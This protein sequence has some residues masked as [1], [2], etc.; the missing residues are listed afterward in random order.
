M[1]AAEVSL[2]A[3]LETALAGSASDKR[4]QVLRQIADLFVC[5]AEQL[6]DAQVELFDDVLAQLVDRIESRARADL[7]RRLAPM[8]NAPPRV[9]RSLA[10]D[11]DIAVAGRVLALSPRLSDEELALVAEGR[12]QKHLM[13]IAARPDISSPLTDVLARRG[14]EEVLRMV[15]GNLG[16]CI[17]D[18]GFRIAVERAARDI[19]LA[20]K[21]VGRS[22]L[23][24]HRLCALIA[25]AT[26]EVRQRLLATA[27][28]DRVDEIRRVID[29]I[30]TDMADSAQPASDR[31][32]I[33][34]QLLLDYPG[35]R[36]PEADIARM[37]ESRHLDRTIAALSL[38]NGVSPE[39]V[40]HLLDG[41]RIEPVL[42]LCRAAGYQWPTVRS[43]VQLRMRR[44]E[45]SAESLSRIC[46]DFSKLLRITATQV[47]KFWQKRSQEGDVVVTS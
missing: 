35:G 2:I 12:S 41:E 42:I 39:I 10:N 29:E 27:P 1:R 28:A 20:Q 11:P 9:L 13:A 16:A 25:R 22:D 17:S 40:E 3:E 46:D 32:A 34:R 44:S 19:I 6:S 26:E 7:G 33:L 8:A 14:N 43:I 23:P 45:C 36:I 15:V 37:A 4:A 31:A 21:L 5:T 38:V 24:P 47:L 18:Y 30:A